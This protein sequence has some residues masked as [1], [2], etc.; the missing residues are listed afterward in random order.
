[1]RIFLFRIAFA[2]TLT[3]PSLAQGYDTPQGAPHWH[4]PYGNTGTEPLTNPPDTVTY[5]NGVG[6]AVTPGARRPTIFTIRQPTVVTQIMTY[7]YDLRQ[8]PGTIGLERED[9]TSYGPW[10]AAGAGGPALPNVYWWIK[11]FIILQPGRYHVID[12]DPHSWSIE[13]S[14]Q[15]AGIVEIWMSYPDSRM[16]ASHQGQMDASASQIV[17]SHGPVAV[18]ASNSQQAGIEDPVNDV[19]WQVCVY[20][21]PAV[22]CGEWRFRHDG[23]VQGLVGGNVVWSGRWTRLGHYVYQYQFTYLGRSNSEWVRFAD[24]NGSGRAT[25]LMGYPDSRMT[26]AHRVGHADASKGQIVSTQGQTNTSQWPANSSQGQG[27]PLNDWL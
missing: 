7:H 10:R 12:S 21:G 3:V 5:Q 9:G 8:R 2:C 18:Q 25:Q 11:P 17:S 24:L 23:G 15:G 6:G 22:G 19:T 26:A 27:D 13:A 4:V 20:P 16:T 14:T 1:M